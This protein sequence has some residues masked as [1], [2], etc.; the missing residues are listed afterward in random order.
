MLE[1]D[2]TTL[3]WNNFSAAAL[4][5]VTYAVLAFASS[6]VSTNNKHDIP[7]SRETYHYRSVLCIWHSGVENRAPSGSGDLQDDPTNE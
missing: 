5:S 7:R 3:I 4:L 2:E 6:P 1:S